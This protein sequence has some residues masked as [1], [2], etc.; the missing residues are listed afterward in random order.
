MTWELLAWFLSSQNSTLYLKPQLPIFLYIQSPMQ[1]FDNSSTTFPILFLTTASSSARNP[2]LHASAA[3]SPS[4]KPPPTTNGV[5]KPLPDDS[6]PPFHQAK[7]RATSEEKGDVCTFKPLTAQTAWL[8]FI[9][10]GQKQTFTQI[11]PSSN[12][13]LAN[14]CKWYKDYGGQGWFLPLPLRFPQL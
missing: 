4:L 2:K 9:L 11:Y 14:N 7:G 5:P 3:W 13:N 8:P 1:I 12:S 6:F 10:Q